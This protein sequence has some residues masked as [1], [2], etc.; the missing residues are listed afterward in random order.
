MR[1]TEL[2]STR[3]KLA[4]ANKKIADL[5][6]R[7]AI[8]YKDVSTNLDDFIDAETKNK[9]LQNELLIIMV[10]CQAQEHAIETHK[11]EISRLNSIV[12]TLENNADRF[13]K[14]KA[15]MF[16]LVI[17]DKIA[18]QKMMRIM[19][20][21]HTHRAKARFADMFNNELKTD[22]ENMLSD[23]NYTVKNDLPF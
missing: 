10:K 15:K 13:E 14:K 11:K 2:N 1:S 5:E 16:T 18:T 6:K 17:A 3:A 21:E 7:L 19:K 12:F 20:G 23:I 4:V 22:V 8:A 9:E